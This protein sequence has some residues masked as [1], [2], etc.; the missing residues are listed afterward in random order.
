VRFVLHGTR[1]NCQAGYTPS[2]YLA[3]QSVL[4]TPITSLYD[5]E[6]EEHSIYISP[7]AVELMT[8]MGKNYTDYFDSIGFD[9]KRLAGAKVLSLDNSDPYAHVDWIANTV[10]GNYLDHGVRVNQVYTSY[11]I[12]ADVWSQRV[13]DFAGPI[14]VS[15]ADVPMKLLLVNATEPEDVRVPYYALLIGFQ[16]TDRA[17]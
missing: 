6:A 5:P 14:D 8:M 10:T 4:P 13:G 12:A 2:C 16:F 11:R 17:T 15:R 9:W 3:Y 7:N 1:I